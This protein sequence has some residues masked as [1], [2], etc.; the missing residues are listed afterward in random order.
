MCLCGVLNNIIM[1]CYN[2]TK[3]HQLKNILKT[4]S[5]P[6]TFV[7]EHDY[8]YNYLSVMDLLVHAV[9]ITKRISILVV[10]PPIWELCIVLDT[11]LSYTN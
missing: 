1:V 7:C 8:R 6:I 9:N 3:C 5:V 4:L 11:F 2:P 10:T